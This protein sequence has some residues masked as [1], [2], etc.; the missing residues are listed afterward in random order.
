VGTLPRKSS[1]LLFPRANQQNP[2]HK[3]N[4]SCMAYYH[5]EGLLY[6]GSHDRTV[7]AWRVS[8]RKCV[9]SFLA[10][11]DNINSMLVNQDD[12]CLFTSSSDGSVKI[13]RR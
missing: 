3:E 11:E 1:F 5:S 9:D 7:K 10:H 2:K 8:D 6:T 12:G 13:W 4:V